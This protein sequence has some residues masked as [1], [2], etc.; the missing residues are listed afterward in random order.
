MNQRMDCGIQVLIELGKLWQIESSAAL[1]YAQSCLSARGLSVY[2]LLEALK[3]MGVEAKAYRM[4]HFP[5]GVFIAHIGSKQWGHYVLVK[6][7]DK[8]V[9]LY[10]PQ[11]G[12]RVMSR[13]KFFMIWSKTAILVYQKR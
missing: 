4:L 5:Q 13:F 7:I 11:C 6:K 1:S 2:E 3:L 12:E 10:D 9:Q 8:R